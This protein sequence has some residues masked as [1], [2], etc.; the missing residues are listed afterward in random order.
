MLLAIICQFHV[1]PVW[2]H[3]LMILSS[4]RGNVS[5]LKDVS[6]NSMFTFLIVNPS[7][8]KSLQ[9]SLRLWFKIKND[10]WLVPDSSD[11][12]QVKFVDVQIW[13]CKYVLSRMLKRNDFLYLCICKTQNC[14]IGQS[15]MSFWIWNTSCHNSILI[16]G[17]KRLLGWFYRCRSSHFW[18]LLF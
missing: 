3:L 8:I 2:P 12:V 7:S 9:M 5:Y 4:K 18:I 17:C 14:E 1:W 6:R 15:L 13:C 11:I 10:D 16:R